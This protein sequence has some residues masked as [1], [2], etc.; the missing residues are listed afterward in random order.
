FMMDEID[1]IG[2]DF[3]GDPSSALLE[4]LDPEQNYAFSDHYLEVP[5]DLSNVMFITT[6][7]VLDTVPPALKD[8]MEVIH[9]PGYTEEEKVKIAEQFLIPKQLKAHGLT[10]ENLKMDEEALRKIIREHT[11]EAGVRNLERKFATVCRQVA[12]KVVEG[13]KEKVVITTEKLHEVLGPPQFRYGMAEEKDEVGVATGLAWT[14]VGGDV[15]SVEATLMKGDGKL[16]LTGYLGEIMRESG[17][18][19]LSYA[20]SRAKELN[21]DEEFYSH[22]DIHIHVPAGSIPKDGPSAGITMATSLIS[23]LTK[24]PVK[25]DICMT[26]EITLRGHVLPIGGIKEKVLAAHRAGL[27]KIILPRDN[28]K[29]LELV[30]PHVRKELGFI[31][32]ENMD[33]VLKAALIEK[34]KVEKTKAKEKAGVR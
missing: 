12:R 4:V 17:Q 22:Y 29:D 31:F 15:M 16:N 13:E 5:F 32:V 19:A 6:A 9:F 28:E 25:K 23:A 21:I 20:R 3:R 26:G 24:K 18:A 34:T 7:N 11:R 27:K 8:R 10:S 1:K 2:T 33:Q 30:P 14:E